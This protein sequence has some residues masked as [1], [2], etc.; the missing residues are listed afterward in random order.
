LVRG[1]V[2]TTGSNG[3]MGVVLRDDTILS[4][5]PSSQTSIERFAFDPAEGKLGMVLRVSRGVIEYLSG[6]ISKLSPGSVHI[7]TPVA[8]LGI[9]G[10]HLVARIE[11]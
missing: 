2:L 6:R 9:R 3:A 10:T 4:L 7:E 11:P 5:G 8:T 1:D